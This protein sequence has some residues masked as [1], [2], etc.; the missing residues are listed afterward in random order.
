MKAIQR[1]IKKNMQGSNSEWKESRTLI[2]DLEQKEEINTQPEQN[3]ETR[4]QK[5]EERLRNVWDNF[6]C[7]NI[8]IIVVRRRRGRARNGKLI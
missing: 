5:H 3:E 2:N 1:E 8:L 6:R 4:I 7:S